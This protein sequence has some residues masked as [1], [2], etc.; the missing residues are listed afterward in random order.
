MPI[1]TGRR[2]QPPSSGVGGVVPAGGDHDGAIPSIGGPPP[3]MVPHGPPNMPHPTTPPM[4]SHQG[5][6]PHH[7]PPMGGMQSHMGPGGMPPQPQPGYF[8]P[9]GPP[10]PNAMG[11]TPNPVGPGFVPGP[12]MPM[13]GPMNPIFFRYVSF[14]AV[15]IYRSN[16][17]VTTFTCV[18]I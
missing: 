10:M 15:C 6:S 9:G 17:L 14:G 13:H 8:S 11:P 2:K 16:M 18:I 7:T 5:M 1:K 12:D 4:L 3:H